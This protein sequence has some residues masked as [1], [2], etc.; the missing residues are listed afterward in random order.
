MLIDAYGRKITYLRV[1]VTDRCNLHCIYCMPP[2]GLPGKSHDAILRFEEIVKIVRTAAE[3]GV[4]AVRL[5]G[6]EPLVRK[7]LPDL[8]RMLAE[9]PGIEDISLTTNGILL[10]RFAKDLALA[11]LR[12]VNISVDTLNADKF[13]KITRGGLIERVWRGIEEAE[14][15]HLTPIKLNVV[16]MGGVNDDE[17]LDMARLSLTE[18]WHIRFIELMPINNRYFWG[19]GFPL[20]DVAYLSI[21]KMLAIL[22]PLK[23]ERLVSKSSS[24]PAREYRLKGAKG[25][26]GFI[27]PLG[28][29]FCD[30]CNRLR[31]TSDGY[32]RPCLLSDTEIP[33]M[34]ALRSGDDIFPLLEQAISLKPEGHELSLSN[35][36]KNR[37]MRDIGG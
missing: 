30:S 22:E 21:Q 5:T 1:S 14:R 2:E 35:T 15:H 23:L 32:L 29:H 37:C 11:G 31:L 25:T 34:K 20:P 9:I 10:E 4:R 36:P 13:A 27:S 33:V 24:G 6:G 28:E 12:R 19:P 3:H 16:A 18:P 8:V 26:I 17:I 7:D